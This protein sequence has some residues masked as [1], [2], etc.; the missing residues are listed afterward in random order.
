MAKNSKNQQDDQKRDDEFVEIPEDRLEQMGP[1]EP[2]GDEPEKKTESKSEADREPKQDRAEEDADEKA[3]EEKGVKKPES[4]QDDLL[5]DVRQA[6]AAEEEVEEPKGFFGRLWQ[7]L[8]R[9]SKTEAEKPEVRPE[10][11]I[12]TEAPGDTP[13]P[14]ISE[15]LQ[16]VLD[17]LTVEAE[18]EPE[19]KTKP[20]KKRTP[21]DKDEEKSIQEFFADLEA[22]ADVVPEEGGAPA[23]E[24]QEVTTVEP[25]EVEK[26]KVPRLPAKSEAEDE[27]DFEAV[28]EVALEDYDETVVEPEERK[29]PLREEVR[30]T[31]RELKP[32]ERFLL[33]G[34]GIVTVGVLL[35]S[36]VFLIV[37]SI[38]IPTP[39]PTPEVDLSETVYPT[40]LTLPGGWEFPLGRGSVVDGKW[41]PDGAEWLVGTEISRWV[42]LPW[43]LQLEA[44]LR[45]LNT[46][47]QI[48]LTMSNFDELTFNVYSIQEITMEEL[49]A[50]DPMVPALVVVLYN[51]EEADGRFWTVTALP[52]RN[53]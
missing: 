37:N 10:L 51:D 18:P 15:D 24:A 29:K 11:E 41:T 1:D 28:R 38:S 12:E 48:V 47:D 17:E 6:L 44:V 46:D 36:G 34:V 33:Y 26:V 3:S 9:P 53:E 30:Q 14:D 32:V 45:T 7:K 5:A 39:T 21:K 20:K 8:R 25:P 19:K 52:T 42:A 35:F 43:S 40:R 23:T 31:V 50:T 4:S 2:Q 13:E 16:G 27:V 49:L 22:M